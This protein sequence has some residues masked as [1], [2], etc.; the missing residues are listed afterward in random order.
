MGSSSSCCISKPIEESPQQRSQ[1]ESRGPDNFSIPS[2]H[3]RIQ[4]LIELVYKKK[5]L[6][7]PSINLNDKFIG[8]DGGRYLAVVLPY[9]FHITTLLLKNCSIG[10]LAAQA[11]SLPLK[12]L[13]NLL[14]LDLSQNE[15]GPEGAQKISEGVVYMRK[16]ETLNIERAKLGPRGLVTLS[17][18]LLFTRNLKILKLGQNGVGPTGVSSLAKV[19]RDVT[20]LSCLELHDNDIGVAG[21][22]GLSSGL[23]YLRELK[24]LGLGGNSLEDSGLSSLAAVLPESL[25]ELGLERNIITDGGLSLLLERL[26]TYRRLKALMLDE[27]PITRKSGK[28]LAEFLESGRLSVIGLVGCDMS[29]CRTE[30]SLS[31]PSTDILL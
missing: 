17:E 14:E 2:M 20:Q 4:C 16:L 29:E 7:T 31:G 30:L 28:G 26:R 6:S 27:N 10:L 8:D 5:H 3:P 18:S 25:V 19:L 13:V 23:F 24:K 21:A 12:D 11:L 9:Y 22:Y 1:I 15:L